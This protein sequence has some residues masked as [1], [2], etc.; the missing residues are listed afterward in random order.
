MPKMP[1]LAWRG[2]LLL[3]VVSLA[4]SLAVGEIAA[5]LLLPRLPAST[6][7]VWLPDAACGYR[8][9][10]IPPGTLP[11]DHD[12]H[13]NRF[14]FRDRNY[15]V[16]RCD[17]V[18]RIVGIGDSFVYGAVPV[19]ENFLQICQDSLRAWRP[20]RRPE[21]LRLG[22]PGFSP[23]NAAGLLESFGLS[24]DPALVVINFFVGNDITGIPVRGRVLGGRMYY[25]YSPIGWL[26]VARKSQLF[27][28]AEGVVYRGL[29]R[30]L[31]DPAPGKTA[32]A[33]D[34]APVLVDGLYLKILRHNVPVYLRRPDR[35]LEDLWREAFGYLERI[36]AACREAGV[37][38]LLVLIPAEEQIDP[39]VRQQVVAGLGLAPA[40]YD[41][42][43][44]QRRLRDWADRRNVPALDL[45]PIMRAAHAD[46]ARLYVPNDTHWNRRGNAV[47]GAALADAIARLAGI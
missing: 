33:P 5:R 44:P 28:L 43:A 36:D 1:S 23:E 41:F 13:I 42:E 7:A 8:L 9:R 6:G 38:W 46:T 17:S 14:G 35:R 45:L 32:P 34:A 12:D 16:A 31:R 25:P 26:N 10:P 27:Q 37:P 11:E 2:R 18:W 4:A 29:K 21:V 3:A 19:A 20:S 24:L 22:C 39:R 30:R 15:L 47:A 40:A